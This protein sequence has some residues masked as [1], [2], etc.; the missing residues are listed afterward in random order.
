MLIGVNAF[1]DE[2][3]ED[4]STYPTRKY[5]TA[6]TGVEW[7]LNRSFSVLAR[8][9]YLWQDYDDEPSDATANGFLIS[10]VYEPKRAD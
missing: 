7:R 1:R 10:L 9:N 8:Y 4:V 3:A 5:I 6:E 2:S